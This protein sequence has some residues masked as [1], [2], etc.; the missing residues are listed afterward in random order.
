M[1]VSNVSIPRCNGLVLDCINEIHLLQVGL[2]T[3][4][5]FYLLKRKSSKS[6]ALFATV[7]LV[8]SVVQPI[9]HITKPWYIWGGFAFSALVLFLAERAYRRYNN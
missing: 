3:G 9:H 7:M 4:I 8:I 6:A 2:F 1:P 5:V